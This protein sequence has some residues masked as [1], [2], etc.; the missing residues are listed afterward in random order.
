MLRRTFA[1]T[2][3]AT[4]LVG[5]ALAGCSNDSGDDFA[6][7]SGGDHTARFVQ[8]PWADLVVETQIAMQIL[9]KL[10]YQTSTNEVSVPLAAQAI[11]DD[12]ADAYLGNWWPSQKDTFQPVLDKGKAEVVGTL[13]T[14]T[15]YAPAVPGYVTDE[16]GVKSLADLD[17]YA[18]KFGKE[19]LGIEPGSPG[20]ATIQKAIDKDAYGLGDWKLTASSTEAM[21]AEVERRAAKKQPVVFL[22]WSPHWMTLEWNLTFLD[23]PEHVWAGAGEIR[24][25]ARAGL[26]TDDPNLKKFLSNIKVDTKTASEFINQVDKEGKK[27]EDIASAWIKA[28]PDTVKEWLNGV[29]TSDGDPAADAVLK[30]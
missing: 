10:G 15:E 9:D 7:S 5:G 27:A 23:D 8:Q 3:A 26:D 22:G 17:K 14:G 11:S 21:L 30:S 4:L 13:L 1:A 24:T 12:Q 2:A 20:N 6:G 25:L 19:I 18:D 16:L 29:T 28:N